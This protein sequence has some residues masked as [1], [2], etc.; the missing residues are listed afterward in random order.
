MNHE[1]SRAR[2]LNCHFANKN[3][4]RVRERER[5]N[6]SKS[7]YNE[8]V[9]TQNT[10]HW[11]NNIDFLCWCEPISRRTNYRLFSYSLPT[12]RVSF[13]CHTKKH[14]ISPISLRFANPVHSSSFVMCLCLCRIT[15][16]NWTFLFL[17]PCQ[18]HFFIVFVYLLD[19]KKEICEYS[20]PKFKQNCDKILF[21]G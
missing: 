11:E 2:H 12:V 3:C 5:G 21:C 18:E 8:N 20:L 16:L 19:T 6:E 14:F 17:F 9:F 7:D 1:N 4:I 15:W 10:W 13:T